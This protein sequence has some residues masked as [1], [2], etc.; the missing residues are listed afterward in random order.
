MHF[1]VNAILEWSSLPNSYSHIQTLHAAGHNRL[2]ATQVSLQISPDKNFLIIENLLNQCMRIFVELAFY[3][4]I[5]GYIMHYDEISL[6]LAV[7]AD[8]N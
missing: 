5:L 1:G 2:A 8:S 7:E 6:N 4:L 3:F